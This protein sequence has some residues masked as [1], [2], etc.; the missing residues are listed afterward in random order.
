MSKQKYFYLTLT[1]FVGFV[2]TSYAQDTGLP[3]LQRVKNKAVV[4]KEAPTAAVATFEEFFSYIKKGRPEL[5]GDEKAQ[6]RWLAS[7]L[8]RNFLEYAKRVCPD[9]HDYPR[10]DFFLGVWNQPTTY[11]IIGTRFYDYHNGKNPIATRAIIDVLYEWGSE[12][13]IHNQYPGVRQLRSFIFIKENGGWKL[14][15]IYGF[16]D[17][18]TTSESLKEFFRTSR[19]GH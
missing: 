14:D 7:S 12:D 2:S 11:S 16:N 15:D 13:S 10:N 9:H 6:N 18:Y 1:I 8:K 4:Q 3:R 5:A 17:E 19:P